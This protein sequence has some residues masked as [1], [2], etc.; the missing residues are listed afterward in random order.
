MIPAP[1]VVSV[2]RGVTLSGTVLASGTGQPIQGARV[3]LMA[4][5]A[6]EPPSPFGVLDGPPGGGGG[7]P[8]NDRRSRFREMFRPPGPR[9]DRMLRQRSA[10]D[11][12]FEF[13]HAPQGEYFVRVEMDGFADLISDTFQLDQDRANFVLELMP[14]AKI[15]G[16]VSGLTGGEESVR[17]LAFA[18]FGRGRMQDVPVAVDGTYT[19]EDVQPGNYVLRAFTGDLRTYVSGAMRRMRS[20]E[21][22]HDLVVDAGGGEYRFD[23]VVDRIP[24][25]RI[26]GRV[27]HNGQPGT[28]LQIRLSEAGNGERGGFGPPGGFGRG[29][30]TTDSDGTFVLEDVPVGTYSL[31]VTPSRRSRNELWSETVV[32]TE[33][34]TARV[35]VA[36]ESGTLRGTVTAPDGTPADQLQ[37][38]I[39]VLPGATEVPENL[40]EARTRGGQ[41]IRVRNGEFS[42]DGVPTGPALLLVRIRGREMTSLQAQILGDTEVTLAAGALTEDSIPAAGGAGNPSGPGGVQPVRR[43][44]GGAGR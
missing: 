8:G 28:N 41:R 39:T 44:R 33:D 7:R 4:V 5:R 18:G 23:L 9:G 43:G 37:G 10:T 34:A 6:D 12:S 32:V 1:A 14:T 11:G 19:I 35:D 30:A 22:Q 29:R 36:V 31:R 3:D 17:V 16:T 24:A 40:F 2:E 27:I 13:E 42:E 20:E 38:T 26:E 21:M 15:T 25:G